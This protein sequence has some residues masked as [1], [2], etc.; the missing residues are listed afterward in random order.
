VVDDEASVATTVKMLLNFDGHEVETTRSGQE[1]LA[2]FEVGEFDLV[3]TDFAMPE[4]KGD[5]LAAAIKA[6]APKQPIILLTGYPGAVPQSTPVD[7]IVGK[8][9]RLE[10]LRDAI[11]QVLLER[12]LG[13]DQAD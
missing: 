7:R 13:P 6:R 3:L 12:R 1:A 11:S 10:H 5:Q 2:R 8:P 4:M 9:F